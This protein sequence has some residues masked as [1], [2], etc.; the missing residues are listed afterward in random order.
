MKKSILFVISLTVSAALSATTINFSAGVANNIAGVNGAALSGLDLISAGTWDGSSFTSFASGSNDN[1]AAGPGFFSNSFGPVA[2]TAGA[3]L[4]FS[5]STAG[6]NTGI[7]YYDIAAGDSVADQWTLKGGDGS[8]AD[9]NANA[10]D[11]SDLAVS[12]TY[13]SLSAN[14]VLINVEFSGSNAA[15]VPSFN[16]TAVPEPSAYAALAGLVALGFVMLRRR[17]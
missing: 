3:Q 14:A 12:G 6:A 15:G 7:V 1:I 11:L 17:A 2:S 16:L 9:F 8:G 5:W 4:A 10:I 13:D